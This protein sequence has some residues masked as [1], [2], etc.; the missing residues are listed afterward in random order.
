MRSELVT[1]GQEDVVYFKLLDLIW[2][3]S[4]EVTCQVSN[5]NA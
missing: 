2:G 5:F 3:V 1:M 4:I